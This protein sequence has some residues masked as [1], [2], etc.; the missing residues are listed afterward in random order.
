[1]TSAVR[2]RARIY[3]LLALPVLD[4]VLLASGAMPGLSLVVTLVLVGYGLVLAVGEARQRSKIIWRLRNRL[5]VTYVFVGAVPVVLILALAACGVYIVVGQVATYLVSAELTRRAASLE[6]PAR[7]LS[8]APASERADIMKQ[9]APLLSD[10]FPGFEVLVT[11]DQPYRFP[12]DNKLEPPQGDWHKFTGL[13]SDGGK[14]YCMS[15]SRTGGTQAVV[16]APLNSDVLGRIVPGLGVVQL[17]SQVAGRAPPATSSL[18][19]DVV[20]FNRIDVTN[21]NRPNRIQTANLFLS[22]RPSAVLAVVFADRTEAAQTATIVFIAIALLLAVVQL[23]SVVIGVTM[24]RT[25]TGAVHNLYEGTQRIAHGDFSHRIPVKGRDQ[26]ASLG[27]SFNEMSAQLESLVRVTREKERLESELTIASEV[28][29]QLFPR[30]APPMRTIE[31]IGACIPARSVSGDYYDYLLLPNGNLAIAIG[32][33]AGKGISAALLMASIQSIMRTQLAQ[34][35]PI[36]VAAAGAIG[37]GLHPPH[38]STADVVSRLNRQLYAN[39]SP[40]KYATF[41]FG[42]YDEHSRIMTYTNA[43]HLPPLLVCGGEANPLEVT[44]T[45]VG[46]FPTV[47]YEEK[48]ISMCPDDMLIAYTDGIT[49]PENAYG[50]EYGLDR[51]SESVLRN[52]HCEP[53]EIVAKVMES[54][55]NWSNAPEL[56]DD[57]T[58]MIAKG[59]G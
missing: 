6:N 28:Q 13:A 46:L 43:G 34:G 4:L 39:T 19:F 21:W 56:P 16:A 26:L 8:E 20:W 37:N 2:K 53:S 49:E 38:L 11:G 40:E 18:D 10:R 25:I 14:F 27:K 17:G 57:M 35:V 42:L 24:T 5:F 45:V 51:L 3:I 47:A 41:F 48:T 23:G 7:F 32:D 54:V 55:K 12:A 31:L 1:M 22:T 33:V 15:L 50:E 58:V 59:I 44:G 29:N 52:R 36:A 9:M 30:A